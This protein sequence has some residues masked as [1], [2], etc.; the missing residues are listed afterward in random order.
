MLMHIYLLV[1]FGV[2]PKIAVVD[3]FITHFIFALTSFIIY[4]T[5]KYYQPSKENFFYIRI[6]ALLL[7][8]GNTF[9]IVNALQYIYASEADYQSLLSKSIALR[10]CYQILMVATI[11][12]IQWLGNYM[13]EQ[14]S[15]GDR[16]QQSESFTKEAE[17]YNLRQQLQ[18]HFLFNSL[19]SISS[20]AG[21]RPEEARKMIQQLSEFLRH[22]LRKDEKQLITLEEELYQLNL[23]L[24]IEKVRFGNRLKSVVILDENCEKLLLPVLVLQP[25]VENAIKF[26]LYDTLGEVEIVIQSKCM[27]GKWLQISIS[28]PFDPSTHAQNTGTGFGIDSIKRRLY[29]LYA[30]NDLVQIEMKENLFLVR[31]NIPQT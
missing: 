2:D 8:I 17:L 6:W 5:L 3:S 16:K 28:N 21:S 13:L 9:V 23:Y 18:P 10:F 14:Q 30:N 20:L 15:D 22:T 12:L 4:I 19:N 7:A 27:D 31:I 26:G 1:D 25:L 24:E 11:T 29:L